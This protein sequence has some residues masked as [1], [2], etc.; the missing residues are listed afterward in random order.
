MITGDTKHSAL[1]VADHLGIKKHNVLYR[2]Y[3]EDKR[4]KVESLQSQG[5]RVLFIG[6]GVNDS[7]VLAQSDVGI[8]INSQSH[9]TVDAAS[10][11]LMKDSLNNV[12]DALR[13]TRLSFQRIKINYCWAFVYNITLIPIAMGILYPLLGIQLSPKLAATAMALSSVSVVTSS[14][15]L[16]LY[17]PFK[18]SN[19]RKIEHVGTDYTDQVLT[20]NPDTER[21][22]LSRGNSQTLETPEKLRSSMNEA[23]NTQDK[24]ILK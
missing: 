11:V 15:L 7:P 14:L 16:K 6:D 21:S 12:V 1:K 4:K 10:I 9:I 23:M 3:P 5:K 18:P 13:I 19:S 2:A 20:E 22:E 8:A 17:R 24:I